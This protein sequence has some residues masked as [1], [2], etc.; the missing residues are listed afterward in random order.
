MKTKV[1]KFDGQLSGDIKKEAYFA[2]LREKNKI[3]IPDV[4]KVSEVELKKDELNGAFLSMLDGRNSL[5]INGVPVSKIKVYQGKVAIP[6][7][8]TLTF[9]VKRVSDTKVKLFANILSK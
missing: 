4:G 2:V 8:Y 6:V 1:I 9:G 3:K 5:S 7:N